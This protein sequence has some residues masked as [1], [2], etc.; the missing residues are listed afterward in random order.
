MAIAAKI[1]IKHENIGIRSKYEYICNQP[2]LYFYARLYVHLFA[3]ANA[4]FASNS[5]E[6]TFAYAHNIPRYGTEICRSDAATFFFLD[7]F[8]PPA[9]VSF[10]I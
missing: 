3:F 5:S 6:W 8:A 4:W 2:V 1:S 9:H 7:Q 10:L